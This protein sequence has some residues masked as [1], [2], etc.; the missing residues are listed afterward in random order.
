VFDA[1]TNVIGKVARQGRFLF[2]HITGDFIYANKM[3]GIRDLLVGLP[4]DFEDELLG[5][6]SLWIRSR[7]IAV[8]GVN[9][10]TAHCMQTILNFQIGAIDLEAESTDLTFIPFLLSDTRDGVIGDYGYDGEPFLMFPNG[11]D[12]KTRIDIVASVVELLNSQPGTLGVFHDYL[13]CDYDGSVEIVACDGRRV[14]REFLGYLS[15]PHPDDSC[16]DELLDGWWPFE[17]PRLKS[18]QSKA[19]SRNRRSG[20]L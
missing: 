10:P 8:F 19:A 2:V 12:E 9:Q 20:R 1:L 6:E 17:L 11:L 18:G 4:T 5:L 16:H 14:H 7:L 13:A 15:P 3:H